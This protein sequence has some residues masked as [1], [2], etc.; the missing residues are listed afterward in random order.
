MNTP[1]PMSQAQL[2][3]T[4]RNM[5]EHVAASDSFEGSIEYT[6]PTDEEVPEGTF[7][8]VRASYRVGNSM[9]QGMVRLIGGGVT[10]DPPYIYGWF[11]ARRVWLAKGYVITPHEDGR[12]SK[13]RAAIYF[14][15]DSVAQA[16]ERASELLKR[17]WGSKPDK[18]SVE[19]LSLE[20]QEEE[21]VTPRW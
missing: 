1:V 11:E 7:A 5:L 2:C 4:L 13:D 21:V 20:R 18:L 14:T 16:A 15:A 17:G 10:E 6:M 12:D 9:G 19:I 8:L 3:D